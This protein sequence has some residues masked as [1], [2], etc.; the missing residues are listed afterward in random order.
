MTAL[1][2]LSVNEQVALLFGILFGLLLLVSIG[3][4]LYSLRDR[5]ARQAEAAGRFRRDL[6]AVW[7]GT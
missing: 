6:R 3:T 1:R 4:L 7:I 5:P 2:N